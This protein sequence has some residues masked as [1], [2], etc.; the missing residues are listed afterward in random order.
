MK[1]IYS[2]GPWSIQNSAEYYAYWQLESK[3]N[4]IIARIEDISNESL[5]NALLITAAP[6]LFEALQNCV[7]C[8]TMDSDMEEDFWP[9]IVQ[10]K[11]ALRKA[12]GE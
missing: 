1:T 12:K 6:D 7:N 4:G 2:T 8:L 11:A 5:E 9:E 10:A 3:G